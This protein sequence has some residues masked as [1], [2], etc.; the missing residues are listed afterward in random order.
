MSNRS[1]PDDS[2]ES[3]VR[4]AE[5]RLRDALSATLG[6]DAGREAA[7]EALG[8]AWEHWDRIRAMDNPVGY[9]YVLGRDRGRRRFRRDRTRRRSSVA[10]LPV[11]R[12]HTPWI[13][14]QLPSELEH[15]PERQRVVVMLLYCFE[16]SM[17][18]VADFL[19]VSKSTVQSHAERGMARLRKRLG[20]TL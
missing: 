9:L 3:F 7:A 15:L 8:Y 13:E 2:F 11:D 19:D 17:G 18:E 6:S 12:T 5:T 16:W 20:V 14:P 4:E 10:L 1:Q